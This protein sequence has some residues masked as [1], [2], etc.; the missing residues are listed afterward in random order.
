MLCIVVNAVRS[1][2]N[3]AGL[4]VMQAKVEAFADYGRRQILSVLSNYRGASS[5]S[6]GMASVGHHFCASFTRARLT[7][8]Q[9]CSNKQRCVNVTGS[10]TVTGPL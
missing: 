1:S 8:S 3:R 10:S 6:S 5:G 7:D 4:L 9:Q 2:T